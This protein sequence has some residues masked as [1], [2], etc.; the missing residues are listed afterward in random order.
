LTF[1]ESTDESIAYDISD[2]A[3]KQCEAPPNPGTSTAISGVQDVQFLVAAQQ[4]M[5]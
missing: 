5:H 4:E 1:S 2:A 3:P